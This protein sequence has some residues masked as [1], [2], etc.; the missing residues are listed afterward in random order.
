M[1]VYRNRRD[2]GK[3]LAQKLSYYASIPN[4]LVLGIPTGGVVVASE[5]AQRLD[6]ELDVYVIHKLEIPGHE[7]LAL[8]AVSS[9]NNQVL[10]DTL[11]KAFAIPEDLITTITEREQ[12]NLKD[13][14][15]FY[16]TSRPLSEVRGRTVIL[17]DEGLPMG[18]TMHAAILTIRKLSP[19]RLI[20]AVPVAAP[21]SYAE[22][23]GMAD[24]VICLSIPEPFY[25]MAAWYERYESVSDRDV[26]KLIFKAEEDYK[27][28]KR[29]RN[30]ARQ[31]RPAA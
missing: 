7:E 8:G 16:R 10:N 2:A 11:L 4:V 6:A 30:E 1:I 12:K 15:N 9:G 3:Q 24:E 22:L 18:C 31:A 21:Q 28:K 17:V 23:E 27:K 19:A 5:V 29:L 25:S 26:C 20:V 14:E 13:R